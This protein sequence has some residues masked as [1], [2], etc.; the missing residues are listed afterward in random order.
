MRDVNLQKISSL[1][2]NDLN[3]ANF[4]DIVQLMNRRKISVFVIVAKS[5]S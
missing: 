3:P 5:A 1:D 2:K 4:N